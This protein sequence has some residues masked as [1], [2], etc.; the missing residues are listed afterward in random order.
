MPRPNGRAIPANDIMN[1]MRALRLTIL[2]SISRPTMKRNKQ[3]PISATKVRYG[4]DTAGKMLSVKP[5]ILPNAVGPGE[6]VLG[7]GEVAT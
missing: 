4:M 5:G 2:V 3:R 6:G 7:N 1:D